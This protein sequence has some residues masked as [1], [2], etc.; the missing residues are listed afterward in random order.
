[1]TK[2]LF[3]R[4]FSRLISEKSNPKVQPC[5]TLVEIL[6]FFNIQIEDKG[7]IRVKKKIVA[8]MLG[9]IIVFGVEYFAGQAMGLETADTL[10]SQSAL[11]KNEIKSSVTGVEGIQPR[12]RISMILILLIVMMKVLVYYL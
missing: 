9:I 4:Y 10:Y 3:L 2:H 6:G 7:E 11:E 12:S 8:G 1:M 5:V